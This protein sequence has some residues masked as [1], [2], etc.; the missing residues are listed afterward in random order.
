LELILSDQLYYKQTTTTKLVKNFAMDLSYIFIVCLLAL[1]S[2]DAESK[3]KS[4]RG[5]G[6]M[7]W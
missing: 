5:R 4:G 3:Q 6:S 7:W 2:A 1:C